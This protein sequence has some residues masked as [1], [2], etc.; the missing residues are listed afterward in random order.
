M[1][2]LSEVLRVIRLDSAI[3]FNA[4]FSEPWCLATPESRALAPILASGAHVI[5]YHLLSEGRAYLELQDGERVPVSAGDIVTFPHG[6]GH[7][8]GSGNLAAPIDAGAALPGV[9]QRGLELLR[10]GGGGASS[11]FICGFLACDL[12]RVRIAEEHQ[13]ITNEILVH[14]EEALADYVRRETSASQIALK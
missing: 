5:I 12:E 7:V 1:D 2:A 11:R 14:L 9:L 8:L 6:H 13:L 4:E 10:G 3:Y